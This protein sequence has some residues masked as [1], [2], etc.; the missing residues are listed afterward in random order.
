M[1]RQD[2]LCSTCSVNNAGMLRVAA[3]MAVCNVW[4]VACGR[5]RYITTIQSIGHRYKP[6]L[7]NSNIEIIVPAG[8]L[9]T[10][11]DVRIPIR[12]SPLYPYQFEGQKELEAK[13]R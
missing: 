12:L 4:H 3:H 7:R 6:N 9:P 13:S 5:W 10:F 2:V 11:R 1:L 8:V